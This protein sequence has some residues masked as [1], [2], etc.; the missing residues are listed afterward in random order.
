MPNDCCIV[1]T[2]FADDANGQQ[3]IDAL[4]AQRLAACVQVMPIQSWYRWQ[5]KV[6]CDAEKL[7]LIKTTRSLY[8]QVEEVIRTN[9][10]YEVPEIMQ[11]PVENGFSGYLR[12]ITAECQQQP[13]TGGES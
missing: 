3:I 11:V 1:I 10:A 6:N 4:L 13:P 7:V 8:R 2:T 12:W 9:H 5:G